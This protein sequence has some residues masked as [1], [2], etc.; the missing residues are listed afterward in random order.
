MAAREEDV[1]V[2]SCV[3]PYRGTPRLPRA[4][5]AHETSIVSV[6][7][8][9]KIISRTGLLN[10]VQAP[11]FKRYK[12]PPLLYYIMRDVKLS[13][14]LIFGSSN[15]HVCS[16]LRKLQIQC[17]LKSSHFIVTVLNSF[18]LS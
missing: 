12:L 7:K 1:R 15:G 18:V 2:A 14:D 17:P 8:T 4:P 11:N 6:Q 5:P 3:Y 16:D 10:R 9:V 13:W